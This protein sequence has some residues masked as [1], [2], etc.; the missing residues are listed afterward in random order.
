[1]FRRVR[2]GDK[3]AMKHYAAKLTGQLTELTSMVGGVG[4]GVEL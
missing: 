4:R 1:M 3:H 2:E